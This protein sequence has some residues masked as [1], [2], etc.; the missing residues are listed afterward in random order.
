MEACLT[1]EWD[2][3]QQVED[4]GQC[5]MVGNEW[6]GVSGDLSLVKD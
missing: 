3:L 6:E 4:R 2:V 1:V 5:Q